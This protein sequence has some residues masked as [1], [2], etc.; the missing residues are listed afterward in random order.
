MAL[1]FMEGFESRR[2]SEYATR[3]YASVSGATWT[4]ITIP[5]RVRGVALEST[6]AVLTTVPLVS[7]V[8]ETWVLQIAAL[9]RNT[10]ALAGSDI[11]I[12]N[13]AGNQ[14]T[15]RFLDA[16]T[17]DVGSFKIQI[18]R[19]AT[20]LATS[21]RTVPYSASTT[22][23][24]VTF[25][26]KARIH[27]TL[28][29]YEVRAFDWLGNSSTVIAGASNQNTANQGT[30]GADR[31]QIIF[32]NTGGAMTFD[33]IV[34]MDGTGSVNNDFTSAPILVYHELP[35]TDVA[36]ETDW[37]PSAGG[38]HAALV[39]DGTS[40]SGLTDEVTSDVVG[41]IDLYNF[42]N[43]TVALI[44]TSGT[45]TILGVMVD[46]EGQMKT[47]GTRTVHVQVKDGANQAED[48]TDLVYSTTARVSRF[49]ILERNPTGTPAAWTRAALQTIAF[50]PKNAI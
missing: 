28:G 32:A 12:Q 22:R 30:N 49:A 38:S 11:H 39:D 37:T 10:S 27:T 35:S 16:G 45:P 14:L 34:I 18:L 31:F 47:S 40:A 21:A 19:G 42:T 24:W 4:D 33:D 44:P 50:G 26:I 3:L 25:Q 2:T 29:T 36:G 17:P 46:V 6:N 23:G 1:R 13:S 43:S 48:P 41:D 9:K 8:Q 20:V 5:G 7:S 15:I